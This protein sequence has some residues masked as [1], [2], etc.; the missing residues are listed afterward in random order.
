[1]SVQYFGAVM[2]PVSV[3][4]WKTRDQ[5][6]QVIG[7][8]ELF[9]VYVAKLTWP[10]LLKGKRVIHFLDNDSAR[11]GLIKGYSPIWPSLEII[12][13]CVEWD[14]RNDCSSWFA[15]VPTASNIGDGPSRMRHIRDAYPGALCVPPV[16]PS[17]YTASSILM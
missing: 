6:I 2:H 14:Y 13:D 7:Q 12:M 17:G 15:R 8:A 9:P 5:Q 11:M 16:F 1:M 10:T 4:R 3:D